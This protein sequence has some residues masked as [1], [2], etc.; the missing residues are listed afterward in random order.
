MSKMICPRAKECKVVGY[1]DAKEPHEYTEDCYNLF[2]PITGEPMVCIRYIPEQPKKPVE[3]TCPECGHK[4]RIRD[5]AIVGQDFSQHEWQDDG[6]VFDVADFNKERKKLTAPGYGLLRDYGNGAL[7]VKSVDLIP[8]DLQPAEPIHFLT[9]D[10]LEEFRRKLREGYRWDCTAETFDKC[11]KTHCYI[12]PH[13]IE[14]P[15]LGKPEPEMP[16]IDEQDYSSG[17]LN[18]YGGGNIDWWQDYIRCEVGRCNAYWQ[19]IISQHNEQLPTHGQQVRREAIA[20]FAEEVDSLFL[21]KAT[22][23]ITAKNK[24]DEWIITKQDWN[25]IV[26]A[27]ARK[28]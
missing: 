24:P 7:Y 17:F 4:A 25:S 27:M 8:A 22:P 14:R 18:D 10:K 1:C 16:L 28:E 20:E 13:V 6:T 12:C 21:S 3:P 23:R 5:G 2:C 15:P 26:R 19:D 11:L 9:E